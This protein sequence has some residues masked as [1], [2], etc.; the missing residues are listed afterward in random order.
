VKSCSGWFSD[1]SV[2]YLAAGRPTVLQDSGFSHWLNAGKGVLAFSNPV[3]AHHCLL[4]LA[5]N[6]EEHAEAARQT[7]LREFSH[8]IVLPRLLEKTGIAA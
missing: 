7:A 2:C 1:R 8:E 4:D 3:E 5:E 6:Y